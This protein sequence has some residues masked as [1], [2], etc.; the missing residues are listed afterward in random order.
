MHCAVV[1]IT[2]QQCQ[3]LLSP[4]AVTAQKAL[5]SLLWC[6]SHGSPSIN[7]HLWTLGVTIISTLNVL[8]Q[9]PRGSHTVVCATGSRVRRA[10]D[11]LGLDRDLGWGGSSVD[12]I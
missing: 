6:P 1:I 12:S 10:G 3:L 11:V 7:F 4:I 9:S 5:P 2:K 8:L